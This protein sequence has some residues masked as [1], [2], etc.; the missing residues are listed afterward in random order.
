MEGKLQY[1]KTD[2]RGILSTVGVI[3]SH[4]NTAAGSFFFQV[5]RPRS[6]TPRGKLASAMMSNF[7]MMAKVWVLA[8]MSMLTFPTSSVEARG[9]TDFVNDANQNDTFPGGHN[10]R[11]VRSRR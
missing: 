8:L 6:R 10:D 5:S 3:V 7:A 11:M 2:E 9:M 4:K 1:C